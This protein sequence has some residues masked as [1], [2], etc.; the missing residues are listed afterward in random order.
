MN[1]ARKMFSNVINFSNQQLYYSC[2]QLYFVLFVSEKNNV[3]ENHKKS[4][5]E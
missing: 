2:V 1:V 3:K 5:I 4:R